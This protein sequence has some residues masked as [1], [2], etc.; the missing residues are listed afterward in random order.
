MGVEKDYLCHL[1]L[2]I[3]EQ[4]QPIYKALDD[5]P[6]C[7]PRVQRTEQSPRRA[8]VITSI[9]DKIIDPSSMKTISILDAGSSL[10]YISN[11]IADNRGHAVQG[12]DFDPVNNYIANLISMN[13]KSGA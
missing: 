4:Y 10:G 6:E 2:R 11:Y 9:I 8:K 1:F 5:M 3:N 13:I 7:S 12:V